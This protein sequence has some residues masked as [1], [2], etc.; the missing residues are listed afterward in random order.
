M[1]LESRNLIILP[2]TWHQFDNNWIVFD[3]AA[4]IIKLIIHNAVSWFYVKNFDSHD[5]VDH[6]ETKYACLSCSGNG[7]PVCQSPLVV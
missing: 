7:R 4:N 6:T 5:F 1:V 3:K 2:K